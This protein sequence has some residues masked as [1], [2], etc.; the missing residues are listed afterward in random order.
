MDVI[1]V[2]AVTCAILVG[3]AILALILSLLNSVISKNNSDKEYL[4][5]G[6]G[7]NEMEMGNA[8]NDIIKNGGG[9]YLKSSPAIDDEDLDFKP[10]DSKV[11]SAEELLEVE[12]E[13]INC[14][15]NDQ[16]ETISDE[17][18]S[19][20]TLD[21]DN[22][23]IPVEDTAEQSN[24]LE[25]QQQPVCSTVPK[26]E[27]E[28]PIYENVV[29]QTNSE[30]QPLLENDPVQTKADDHVGGPDI[31]VIISENENRNTIEIPKPKELADDN[32]ITDE[33]NGVDKEVIEDLIVKNNETVPDEN[34][35]DEKMPAQNTSEKI[36]TETEVIEVQEMVIQALQAEEEV[37]TNIPENDNEFC[38]SPNVL[39]TDENMVQQTNMEEAEPAAPTEDDYERKPVQEIISEIENSIET[40]EVSI[41]KELADDNI[42]TDEDN[43][44]NKEVIEDLNV[45]N[46]ETVPDESLD[47][48]EKMPVQDTTEKP[49][50][51]L[52]PQTETEVIEVQETVI[53]A[54]QTEDV[55][56]IN[57]AEEAEPAMAPSENDN[58][59]CSSP[60]LLETDENMA[61]QQTKN[62]NQPL[63]ENDAV[64]EK[65][66]DHVDVIGDAD[67]DE[68][69][70]ENEN[71]IETL[72]S[73]ESK[74]MAD[75]EVIE[76]PVIKN[77]SQETEVF[78]VQNPTQENDEETLEQN[79]EENDIIVMDQNKV[80]ED[81]PISDKNDTNIIPEPEVNVQTEVEA[82]E[83]EVQTDIEEAEPAALVEDDNWRKIP[84]EVEPA[85]E[86]IK[87]TDSEEPVKPSSEEEICSNPKEKSLE[88][89]NNTMQEEEPMK[90]DCSGDKIILPSDDNIEAISDVPCDEIPS[91][92]L[93][94]QDVSEIID[95]ELEIPIIKEEVIENNVEDSEKISLESPPPLPPPGKQSSNIR[96]LCLLK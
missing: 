10:G 67:Q 86:E 26:L 47:D 77:V 93:S 58:E 59:V 37:Q 23:N 14:T 20:K 63:L 87:S 17:S 66:D 91:K 42:I 80:L 11:E 35:D 84:I 46:I 25:S 83:T 12:N 41:P 61:E 1:S 8:K 31:D 44:I 51:D 88:K 45:K 43:G 57:K 19:N 40:I 30:N 65:V 60:T 49:N 21:D 95:D 53:Q 92:T 7:T 64:Q 73:P 96:G 55:V 4:P 5:L 85:L 72:E 16:S 81:E 32:I 15:A 36:Q 79:K 74:E 89:I 48:D 68:I 33:D 94:D 38:S 28:D 6:D 76:D 50:D 34:L 18:K 75:Q 69:I 82:P 78:E 9:T 39:E 27:T 13:N 54:P 52:E 22:E 71:S 29:Q 90:T 2:I 62:E 56:Q 24:D 70:S 3:I